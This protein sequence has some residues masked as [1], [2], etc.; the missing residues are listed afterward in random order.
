MPKKGKRGKASRKARQASR[1]KAKKIRA[2]ITKKKWR[3]K[4]KE[5]LKVIKLC[6]RKHRI[7]LPLSQPF[8]PQIRHP[9][10]QRP[11]AFNPLPMWRQ[12]QSPFADLMM[13]Q[14]RPVVRTQL[15]II[16]RKAKQHTRRRKGKRG[17]K[18]GKKGKKGK[19]KGKTGKKGKKKGKSRSR[20]R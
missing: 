20:R 18:K 7:P 14:Q 17:K 19:K 15:V 3:K 13:P 2:H 12:S 10:V 4:K 5:A 9:I 8:R 16:G 1:K 6:S 11:P